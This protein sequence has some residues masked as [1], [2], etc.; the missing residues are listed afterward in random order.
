VTEE[1]KRVEIVWAAGV[2]FG[3]GRAEAEEGG[4]NSR[5]GVSIDPIKENRCNRKT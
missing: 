5:M 4:S 3:R 1:G 2:G